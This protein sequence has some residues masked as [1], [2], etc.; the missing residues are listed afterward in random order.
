MVLKD[1][2]GG[3]EGWRGA[4]GTGIEA[5][6]LDIQGQPLIHSESETSLSYMK[7]FLK[8]GW[9]HSGTCLP[10]SGN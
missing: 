5:E 4:R 8:G 7:C 6:G 3:V 2:G 10:Y 9:R 1:G